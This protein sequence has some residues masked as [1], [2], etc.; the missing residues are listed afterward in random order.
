MKRNYVKQWALDFTEMSMLQSTQK[1]KRGGW[2]NSN[3][4]RLKRH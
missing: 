2:T 3:E 1:K 4:K